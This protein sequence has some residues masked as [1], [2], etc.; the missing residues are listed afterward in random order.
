MKKLL[1]IGLVLC[2]GFAANALTF[3]QTAACKAGLNPTTADTATITFVDR[4]MALHLTMCSRACRDLA[5]YRMTDY[6]NNS[7]FTSPQFVEFYT[8][9]LN[10]SLQNYI[11]SQMLASSNVQTNGINCTDTQLETSYMN[12]MFGII[13]LIGNGSL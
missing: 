13:K 10:G 5:N 6:T 8:R 2:C 12:V 7:Q 11:V 9:G 1:L 3:R 4:I